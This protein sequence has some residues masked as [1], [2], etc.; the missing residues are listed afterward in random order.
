MPRTRMAAGIAGSI[1]RIDAVPSTA[2]SWSVSDP[3]GEVSS[4]SSVA[5]SRPPAVSGPVIGTITPMPTPAAPSG[6][7]IMALVDSTRPVVDSYVAAKG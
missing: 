7:T 3:V 2:S 1:A 6:G 4:V 5:V